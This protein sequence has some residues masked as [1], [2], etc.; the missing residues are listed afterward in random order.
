VHSSPSL[1]IIA[2]ETRVNPPGFIDSFGRDSGRAKDDGLERA[3]AKADPSAS[4]R[5]DKQ[6]D[7]ASNGKQKGEMPMCR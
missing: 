4:L 2:V 1:P 7:R 6:K 3:T 5:D